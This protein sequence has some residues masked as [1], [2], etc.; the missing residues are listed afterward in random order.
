MNKWFSF[1]NDY[2]NIEKPILNVVIAEFFIQMV[3]ATFMLVLPLYMSRMNYSNEEIALFLTF[4]FIGVFLLALPIGK[5]IKGKKLYPFFY[6]SA[7][8]VPLFG[9]AS[10][11]AIY[12]KIDLLIY[13]TLFLWGS[14][15]TFMQILFPLLYYAILRKLIIRPPWR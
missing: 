11:G 14:M 9:L 5:F 13:V 4:R 15:F 12:L 8:G 6:I 1:I 7:I 2:R 3:N 10:I